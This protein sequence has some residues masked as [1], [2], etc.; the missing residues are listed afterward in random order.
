MDFSQLKG[1]KEFKVNDTYICIIY[2]HGILL[3]CLLFW[4]TDCCSQSR[5]T[6]QEIFLWPAEHFWPVEMFWLVKFL[7][8]V[9]FF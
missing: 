5:E 3:V 2:G 1:H 9:N 8:T 6:I 4:P 7:W